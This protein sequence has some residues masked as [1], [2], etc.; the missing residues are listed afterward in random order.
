MLTLYN[1]MRTVVV[2]VFFQSLAYFLQQNYELV[3]NNSLI[4]GVSIPFTRLLEAA[5]LPLLVSLEMTITI[6]NGEINR[7]HINK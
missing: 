7:E 5:N 3:K 4:A 2:F 1:C 6:V